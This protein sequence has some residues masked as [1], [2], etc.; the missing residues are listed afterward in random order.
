MSMESECVNKRII[1]VEAVKD[2]GKQIA[3]LQARIAQVEALSKDSKYAGAIKDYESSLNHLQ[4][5][6]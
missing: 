4:I 5:R 1:M 2:Q 3:E 6:L